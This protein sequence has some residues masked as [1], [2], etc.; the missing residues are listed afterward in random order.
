MTKAKQDVAAGGTRWERRNKRTIS[1]REP[2]VKWY[3]ALVV[4]N[5]LECEGDVE[6][7]DVGEEVLD[8]AAADDGE[9][10]WDLLHQVGNCDCGDTGCQ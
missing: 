7:L 5:M 6:S 8:F 9:H 4:R 10:I 1:A 3:D 2:R